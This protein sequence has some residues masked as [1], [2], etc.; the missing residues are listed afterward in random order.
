MDVVPV[1]SGAGQSE[2]DEKVSGLKVEA[3]ETFR[4]NDWGNKGEVVGL[5]GGALRVKVMGPKAFF[6]DRSTCE[7]LAMIESQ[8]CA[9]MLIPCHSQCSEYSEEPDDSSGT[10]Q[11][12]PLRWHALFDGQQ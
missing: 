11:H 8:G 3:W 5:E 4:G 7:Y 12:G 1:V 9:V 10:G 2:K 6:M